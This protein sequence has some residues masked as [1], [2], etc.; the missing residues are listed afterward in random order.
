MPIFSSIEPQETALRVPGE[1][2][3]AGRNFADHV[4]LRPLEVLARHAWDEHT[5]LDL[6]ADEERTIDAIFP[7]PHCA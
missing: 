2:S 5:R 1:P 4:R 3:G 7:N 6:F